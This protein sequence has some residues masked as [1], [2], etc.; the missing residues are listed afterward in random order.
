MNRINYE[1]NKKK[2]NLAIKKTSP[3]SFKFTN[4]TLNNSNSSVNKKIKYINKNIGDLV[5]NSNVKLKIS[6]K[7]I[8]NCLNDFKPN[9]IDNNT[10]SFS[11]NNKMEKNHSKNKSFIY[12]RKRNCSFGY[13]TTNNNSSYFQSKDSHRNNHISLNK[14]TQSIQS[15]ERKKI[16]NNK[17]NTKI[18]SLSYLNCINLI[19]NNEIKQNNN[20][21]NNNNINNDNI[22]ILN[23]NKTYN[24]MINKKTKKLTIIQ[25]FSK[26]KK[27]SSIM[28]S[29]IKDFINDENYNEENNIKL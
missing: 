23:D 28:N 26:Y 12:S 5:E 19:R 17:N 13:N 24:N 20:D 29:E 14:T 7:T 22:S 18:N 8:N 21:S 3:G 11:N 25:N 2:I 15:E 16:L 10:D 27:K 1:K 6:K 9:L 4:K